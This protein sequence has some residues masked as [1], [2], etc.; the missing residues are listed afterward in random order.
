[1]AEHAASTAD[2]RGAN[3]RAIA[4]LHAA[5]LVSDPHAQVLVQSSDL[6]TLGDLVRSIP[7]DDPCH[8]VTSLQHEADR[9]ASFLRSHFAQRFDID[10]LRLVATFTGGGIAGDTLEKF[11]QAIDDGSLEKAIQQ[12]EEWMSQASA[13]FANRNFNEIMRLNQS[14]YDL[15]QFGPVTAM[16]APH[17]SSLAQVDENVR[18]TAL[19]ALQSLIGQ[20]K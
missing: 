18:T 9:N 8:T 12:Y 11:E 7:R 14:R 1:M 2:T 13:A 4:I 17:I 5:K 10:D 3:V 20:S 16:F 19:P 15:D 6:S